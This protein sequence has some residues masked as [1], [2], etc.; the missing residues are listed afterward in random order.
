MKKQYDRNKLGS[1][2]SARIAV[3]IA[4]SM[5]ISFFYCIGVFA[6]LRGV[7]V[8]RII[9]KSATNE[10]IVLS[11]NGLKPW[12]FISVF[13]IWV[14][15]TIISCILI[16]MHVDKLIRPIYDVI[17]ATKQI[18]NGN[19]NVKV[20][21]NSQDEIAI[22]SDS[23]NEM[24]KS[25]ETAVSANE[26]KNTFVANVSHEIR[27][28]MN[29]ILGFSELILQQSTNEEVAGFA[30]DIKRA[31]KNLLAII[32][33]LLDISKIESGKV[34][35]VPVPYYLYYLLS[36]VESII[37]IPVQNKGLEFRTNISPDLPSQLYGDVVRIRQILIN[38]INNAVKFT[39]EGYVEFSAEAS[40]V[41]EEY[42]KDMIM[43]TFRV[44]D[45]GI[46]I[47]NEDKEAI[48]ESFRQVDEKANRGI[49]GTGLGL[50]ISKQ[51]VNLM[52]GDIT[53]DSVYGKGT[54]F[55]IRM[56]QKVLGHQKLS[57]YVLKQG[58]DEKKDRKLF[59]A[60]GV[61]ILAVDDNAVNLRII[62]G[63]LKHYQIDV[64]TA[65]SGFKA[66]SM[67]EK[68]D[69]DLIFMDHMMPEMDGVETVAKIRRLE[70]ETKRNVKVIAISA[71]AI[72]GIRDE[73]VRKG[74]VDYLSKPI[75]IERLEKLL[76]LYLPED[77]IVEVEEKK[78][79]QIEQADFEIEGIDV[80]SGMAKCG[81]VFEDY[82]DILR[83][84]YE[85]GAAKCEE[86]AGFVEN[87]EFEQFTISVHALKSV[88]ANIGAHRLHTMAKIYEIAG[89][90]GKYAFIT[91]NYETLI[92]TY[93]EVV[94]HIGEVL[95]ERN[96]LEE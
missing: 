51:L 96:L 32:N 54:T 25:L 95:E 60:P 87:G 69:F 76:K 38:I 92:A 24:A 75:N 20:E 90:E 16:N 74:F 21:V 49:E 59:Y 93:K 39:R 30:N 2:I 9:E 57:T 42:G 27:T 17:E 73:F 23:I 63:L 15:T 83:I 36:D 52:G 48:F 18:A 12:S 78:N 88:A 61:R 62:K 34:E 81:N 47:R 77:S 65:D 11:L 44:K 72:R 80:L 43:L 28:P 94:D 70:D 7:G 86:L 19:R 33:D 26:A 41:S 58:S 22:L 1:K 53:V 37:S 8:I 71:N 35:L 3:S 13:L 85:Y 89:K 29:A 66:L 56:C 79:E 5:L 82:V 68:E 67:L 14:I 64:K 40:D 46:G 4:V 45:T 50:P 55:T 91:A 31:S 10:R 84:V 6:Y